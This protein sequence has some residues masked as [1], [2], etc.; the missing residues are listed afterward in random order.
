MQIKSSVFKKG[1]RGT[2]DIIQEETPQ[3]A[4]IGR[5]NVGKSSL[6]NYLLGET[7]LVKSSQTP[8]KTKEINFFLINNAFYFVDLPGYGYAKLPPDMREQ[9]AKMIQW[10]FME[11]VFKRLAVLVLDI[12]AGPSV[13]DIE[14][15]RIF[16]EHKQE[17]LIVINKIDALKQTE[18]NERVKMITGEINKYV[19]AAKIFLSSCRT[20]K[21]RTEI[22]AGISAFLNSNK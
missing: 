17:V 18:R 6:I 5:S 9:L 2:D 7:D 19:P 15:L 10:Y 21:G 12:K 1:I 22:L 13:M 4:F 11:P 8:G 3:I 14:M 16:A 20:E